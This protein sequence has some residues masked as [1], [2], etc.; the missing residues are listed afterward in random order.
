MVEVHWQSVIVAVS[1]ISIIGGLLMLLL[2]PDGP[3][4]TKGTPF[5][6]KAFATIFRSRELRAA[7]FGYFGHMWELYTFYAFIPFF[8]SAYAGRHSDFPMNISFWSFAII[9][10]GAAGC[11]V[12]GIISK[13]A[14]SA[15]VAWVQLCCSGLL[16]LSSPLLFE[17]PAEYFLGILLL[18]GV[19]VVGDSPQF[20]ALIARH[21]PKELVGS[22]LTVGNC[23]GFAITIVSIQ[24]ISSLSGV[25]APEYIFS[26]LTIG[27]VLGLLWFRRLVFQAG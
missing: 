2:V 4:L 19:V 9:A 14:G 12:G 26:F 8:L 11:A 22:A 1:C 18:W 23:I 16:S 20:S 21:A 15:N 3:F 6:A 10:A 7:A 17:L 5:S 25:I 13:R 24:A 27:P